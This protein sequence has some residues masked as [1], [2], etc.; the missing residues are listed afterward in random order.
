MTMTETSY[1]VTPKQGFIIY[2]CDVEAHFQ[3]TKY[4][5]AGNDSVTVVGGGGNVMLAICILK[6]FK[7]YK[8][9]VH[10]VDA[11]SAGNLLSLHKGA[12]IGQGVYFSL[13]G[14]GFSKNDQVY[15]LGMLKQ[16][17]TQI[18]EGIS[19]GIMDIDQ[20]LM[21]AYFEAMYHLF[22]VIKDNYTESWAML[23]PRDLSLMMPDGTIADNTAVITKEE[24]KD[25]TIQQTV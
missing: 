19:L 5:E 4:L 25:G 23:N 10:V 12:K 3:L 18:E 17:R 14:F 21:T 20:R 6:L 22:I 24:E 7:Q 16:V 15:Q 1:G 8:P 13:H 11:V 2:S 9:T